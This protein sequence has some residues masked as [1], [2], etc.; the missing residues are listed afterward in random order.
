MT[1]MPAEVSKK[2]I[3][4]LVAIREK[5]KGNLVRLEEDLE[6]AQ[7][8]LAEEAGNDDRISEIASM[9]VGRELD[10]SLEKN[11]RLLLVSVE[12]ALEAI[13]SGSYGI[14]RS[15]GKEIPKERLEALPYA[16]RC[17]ECQRRQE[18]R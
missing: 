6:T 4:K 14:C 15:C 17:V 3:E 18:T 8:E 16:P 11:V 1:I 12:E 9:A 2:Q 7:R 5:L 13:N 10:M